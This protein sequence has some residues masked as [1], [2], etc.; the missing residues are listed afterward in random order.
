ML[1]GVDACAAY[2][3]DDSDVA[4][5]RPDAVVLAASAEDVAAT[6]EIAER[7]DVPVT[8]RAGGHGAHRRRGPGAR[9]ASS[10]RRTRSRASRTSTARTSSPSS[11]RA[12]SPGELHAAVER[13][14]LF[15]APDPNSLESCMI[16]GNLAENAGG[17]RVFKYG[18]TR[19]WVLGLEACLDGRTRAC[20]PASAR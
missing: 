5:A 13:E 7:A 3:S 9:A 11:S 18:A 4:G 8:P 19:D 17:P 6:L 14:G 16:G 10:S 1:T 12:S 2:A 20:A 15:Y